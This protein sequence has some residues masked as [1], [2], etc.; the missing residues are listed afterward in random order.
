MTIEIITSDKII[1]V[2]DVEMLTI[3]SA[4]GE[5]GILN[6]HAHAVAMVKK[7]QINFKKEKLMNIILFNNGFAHITPDK[8]TIIVNE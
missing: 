2:D 5:M 3:P 8:T 4:T 1:N 7:G 6:G